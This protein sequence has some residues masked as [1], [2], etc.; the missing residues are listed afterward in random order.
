MKTALQIKINTHGID[1]LNDAEQIFA[2]EYGLK[3]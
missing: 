2:S 3:Y 1:M